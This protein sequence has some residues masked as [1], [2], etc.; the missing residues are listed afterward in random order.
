MLVTVIDLK[1]N[2]W[3]NFGPLWKED[4]EIIMIHQQEVRFNN[5]N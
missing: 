5:R 1:L 3:C 4:L 2:L